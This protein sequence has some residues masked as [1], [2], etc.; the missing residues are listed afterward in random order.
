MGGNTT[1]MNLH[2]PNCGP[3]VSDVTDSRKVLKHGKTTVRR[4]RRCCTCGQRVAT[5]EFTESTLEQIKREVKVRA[6]E[7]ITEILS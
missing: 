5:F 2:C 4:R 7:Q 3:T 1:E 6:L